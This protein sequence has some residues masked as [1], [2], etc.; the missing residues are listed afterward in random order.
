MFFVRNVLFLLVLIPSF[1]WG[2]A[3]KPQFKVAVLASGTVNWE[4]QHLK[5]QKLDELNNFDLNIIKV[6]SMSAAKVALT[7][8][9][10]DAIVADWLW[11]A[12]RNSKGE[13]FRFIPFSKQ[14]GMVMKPASSQLSDLSELKGKR[15]GVAGGPLNKGWI[16]LRAAARKHGLNLEADAQVQF[17]SPPLLSQS[18]KSGRLDLLVT[19]WHYGAR[20]E[21]EGYKTVISLQDMMAE[22]GMTSQLPMLGYLVK[23][24]Q[25]DSNPELI[26]SFVDAVM[27]AKNQLLNEDDHWLGLRKLMRAENDQV[28]NALIAGYRNGIPSPITADQIDDAKVFYKLITQFKPSLKGAELNEDMFYKAGL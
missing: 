16:L 26:N 4:L 1:V 19:F 2:G 17:G 15:I 3:E 13:S 9:N 27:A 6:A 20:L 7:S 12:D 14:V 8:G 18:L 24:D 22:L 28:F 21:T 11:A 23:Q 5:N 10:A 25:V